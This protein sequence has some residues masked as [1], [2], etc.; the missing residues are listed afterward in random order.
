MHAGI[1]TARTVVGAWRGVRRPGNAP[2][3]PPRPRGRA[4]RTPRLVPIPRLPLATVAATAVAALL[5]LA[6][7][8]AEPAAAQPVAK[9]AAGGTVRADTVRSQALGVRKQFLVYLPPSY[10][11]EPTRRYP[12]AYYLHGLWGDETNWQRM[13]RID[14]AL[15]SLA[16]AG[17]PE[18]IVVM[19]DGDDAWYTTWNALG[20]SAECQRDT[21]RKEP[22]ASYC[23]P[24]PHYDDYVARDLVAHV[25]SSYRTL[26]DRAHR[27]IGGLSMGGF[28]A[29]TLALRYPDVYAAA[30]SHSGV[31]APLY[32]GP[33]PYAPPAR[34]ASS[35]DS[36]SLGGR[37]QPSMVL[38]F[39]RDTAGWW[40]RDPGRLA[41]R[42]VRGDRA[43]LPAL[44]VDV[45]TEDFLLD[46][47]R[48]FRA[49]LQSLGVAHAYAEWPGAH[50][51][52][53]WRT[54]VP[55][56]LAWM[57]ARIAPSP[58]ARR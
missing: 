22:A 39:G 13:G 17:A 2:V 37:L 35:V 38:A 19:P 10:D 47:N 12:V 6:P 14:R 46:Q 53:Y 30:A 41:E 50:T 18:L 56:S 40:A 25:D 28:G 42:L 32:A 26:A 7:L 49:T 29:L 8:A 27:G 15:D 36:A 9:D 16:R 44:F 55:E 24:W 51:W 5:A 54:H 23:V 48:A 58:G 21:V 1:V 4:P 57:A 52:E 43:R 3:A 45:G 34:W 33:R 31:L 11:R 20:N